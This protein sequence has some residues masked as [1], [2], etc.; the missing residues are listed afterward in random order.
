[1][2]N[3]QETLKA[4]IKNH[5]DSIAWPQES[6]DMLD[7]AMELEDHYDIVLTDADLAEVINQDGMADLIVRKLNEKE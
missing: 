5:I 2:Q 3:Q 7:M 6:L 4:T 1:M